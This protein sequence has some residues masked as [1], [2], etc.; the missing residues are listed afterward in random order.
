M[1]FSPTPFDI[2]LLH[3][4]RTI[5]LR[6]SV[7]QRIRSRIRSLSA[8]E[9]TFREF[10]CFDAGEE[11][12]GG[13]DHD[14]PLPGDHLVLEYDAVDDWDVEGGED[15]DEADDDGPEEEFVAAH[16]VVPV[17]RYVSLIVILG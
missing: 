6:T 1:L 9:H 8:E 10:P 4:S 2:S 15:G 16:V 17:R 12:H 13:D 5:L 7:R 3:V 11:E 14:G